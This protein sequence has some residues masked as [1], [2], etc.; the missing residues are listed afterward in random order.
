MKPF[1]ISVPHAGEAIPNEVDWLSSLPE[2]ILM[3]DVDRY[4]DQLYKPAAESLG[5]PII[6]A[7]WHRYV[8]DCNRLPADIDQN[9]VE[10]S[11][12][13]PGLFTIGYHWSKTTTG[14]TLMKNPISQKLH[15]ELTEKYFNPFHNEIKKERKKWREQFPQVYHLDAHSMPSKG[16]DAHRDSGQKRA[17]IVISDRD[18]TSCETRYTELVVAAYKKVGFDVAVNWPYKGGRVT[19]TY[20]QP[21]EGFHTLQV[22]MNRSLYMDEVTKRKNPETFSFVQGRIRQALTMI[23]ESI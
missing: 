14:A 21:K 3:C 2:N 23:W 9:S 12:N 7:N 16:T 13:G 10:G 8:V 4:V 5:L 1:F 19:E 18:G 11:T 22:E 15:Q 17:E 6:V 20:G